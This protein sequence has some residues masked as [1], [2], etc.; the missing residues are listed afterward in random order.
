MHAVIYCRVSTKEQT[1][2]L[3]LPTQLKTC[4]EYCARNGYVVAREF[5][6]EGESAK[7]TDRTEFQKLLTYCR[8]QK[9]RI[10]AVVVFNISRFARNSLDLALVR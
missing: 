7:T 8:E 6:E 3:S 10:R 2:N 4:Q 9:P 1:Q 5:V